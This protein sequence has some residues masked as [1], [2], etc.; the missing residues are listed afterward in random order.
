MKR[1]KKINY[2]VGLESKNGPKPKLRFLPPS[3][4]SH[5]SL[6]MELENKKKP[7]AWAQVLSGLKPKLRI[8]QLS[9]SYFWHQ[10]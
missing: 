2:E 5:R 4:N 7:Q 1:Y 3:L 9:P 6:G 10:K 8:L